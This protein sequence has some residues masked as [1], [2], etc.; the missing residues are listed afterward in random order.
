MLMPKLADLL[1]TSRQPR[2][3]ALVADADQPML[4]EA[5]G[6]HTL[7]VVDNDDRRIL[8]VE[9]RREE[10]LYRGSEVF[11]E[12]V[13]VVFRELQELLFENRGELRDRCLGKMP[14]AGVIEI[15][16]DGYLDPRRLKLLPADRAGRLPLHDEL[17]GCLDRGHVKRA[18][19]GLSGERAR[20][21]IGQAQRR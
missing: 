13:A 12:T 15:L 21:Q 8:V 6:V 1:A 11:E 4:F 14:R 10:D 18:A 19:D 7:A 16:H 5:G 3:L 17:R 20:T 9:V 2:E